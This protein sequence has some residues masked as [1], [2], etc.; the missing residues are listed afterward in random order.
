[1]KA[2]Y[3]RAVDTNDAELVLTI[4]AADSVLDYSGCCTDSATGRDFLP[5]QCDVHDGS[6]SWLSGYGSATG[7]VTVGP[8][9]IC[10]YNS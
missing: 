8:L 1:V 9:Q 2:R 4:L 5:P 7:S 10:L 6:A 3:F